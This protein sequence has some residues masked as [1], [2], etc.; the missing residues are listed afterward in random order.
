MNK[1]F[2]YITLFVFLWGF[3]GCGSD[4]DVPAKNEQPGK[5][6]PKDPGKEEDDDEEEKLIGS[7][8]LSSTAETYTSEASTRAAEGFPNNGSIG[9]IAGE[10]K[11]SNIDWTSYA[12]I[13]NAAA[14]A[15]S[16]AG[17]V[18]NF[19]W[20]D[21]IKYWPMDNSPLVFM[22]YSPRADNLSNLF[23]SSDRTQLLMTLT[24]DMPDIL[25][26]SANGTAATTPYNKDSKR[27]NL[28]EFR[29]A[30]SQLTV[31]VVADTIMDPSIRINSLRVSTPKDKAAWI[32]PD[33]DNGLLLLEDAEEDFVY[34]LIS[35]GSV[36]FDSGGTTHTV[37]LFPGTEDVTQISIELFSTDNPTTVYKEYMVSY[38]QSI[39]DPEEPIRLERGKNTILTIT[40]KGINVVTDEIELKGTLSPWN[41]KGDFGI[42]IN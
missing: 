25:Y 37:L 1:L 23:L 4:D 20:N 39:L 34:N 31:K 12:D 13:D 24:P 38:F 22:A 28:G 36:A 19:S 27:V 2:I 30:L 41:D 26:A 8:Y 14:T 16:V 33:G 35:S 21:S 7:I 10:Y 3:Q 6:E 29:H 17:G 15:T 9:V 32:L 40:V 5:E 42:I 11:A 18:Y